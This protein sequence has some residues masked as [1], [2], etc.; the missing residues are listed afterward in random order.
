MLGIG[1]AIA[2]DLLSYCLYHYDLLTDSLNTFTLF[3]NCHPYFGITSICIMICSYVTTVLY[4]TFQMNEKIRVAILYPFKHGRNLTK[5][6]KRKSLAVIR[7]EEVSEPTHEEKVYMHNISFIEA[8]SESVL[9]LCLNCVIIR[10]FGTSTDPF[11][12]SI[13]LSGL[14]TSL[15]SIV[16]A[17]A[18][19]RFRN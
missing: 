19:V 9:Q 5:I 11:Q 17:F 1:R 18:Q 2:F 10:K 15:I 14:A 6:I 3:Q 7:G 8:T 12:K 4:L 13:Q 16:L